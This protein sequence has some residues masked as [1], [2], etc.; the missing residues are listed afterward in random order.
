[1]ALFKKIKQ[2]DGVIT[3]YHRI[4]FLQT[5]V[6]QQ[7]CGFVICKFRGPRWRKEKQLQSPIHAE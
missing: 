6:N 4:L 5:T 3:E 7:N 2:P 1:M